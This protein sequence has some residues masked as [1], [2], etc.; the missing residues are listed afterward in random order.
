VEPA[1]RKYYTQCEPEP[2]KRKY[3]TQCEP[4]PVKRKYYTQQRGSGEEV[5]HSAERQH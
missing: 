4:E 5:L 1:K 2:A 3:Y